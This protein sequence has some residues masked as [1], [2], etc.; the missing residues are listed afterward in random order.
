MR[1]AERPLT[2]ALLFGVAMPLGAQ[3]LDVRAYSN[4][5]VGV[6]ILQA[7]YGRSVGNILVDP[8]LPVEGLDASVN[9]WFVKYIRTLG[10]FG[11]S[12]TVSALRPR[13]LSLT[14]RSE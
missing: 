9:L 6:N 14:S 2:I 5:P 12:G 10:F 1:L 3:D 8:S 11:R 7:G 4:V 13:R